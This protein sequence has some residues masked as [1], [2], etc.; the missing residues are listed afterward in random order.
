MSD[1]VDG[2]ERAEEL[3]EQASEQTRTNT[4][5]ESGASEPSQPDVVEAVREAYDEI[6]AGDANANVSSRDADLAALL[7]GLERAGELEDV[8]GAAQDVVG[9]D[10]APSR[11]EAVRSLV[12][13]GLREVAPEATEK[14][15]QARREHLADQSGGF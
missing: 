2:E 1:D 4:E 12:R 10:A 5:P 8:V 15:D 11:A 7:A 14:A 3:F 9:R 13:V 6:D